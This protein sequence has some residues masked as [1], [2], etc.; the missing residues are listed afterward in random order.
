MVLDE[1]PTQQRALLLTAVV[2]GQ[3]PGIV[4]LR[5]EAVP[6]VSFINAAPHLGTIHH[7]ISLFQHSFIYQTLQQL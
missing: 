3:Y 6:F 2:K 5:P 1:P 4:G 7:L